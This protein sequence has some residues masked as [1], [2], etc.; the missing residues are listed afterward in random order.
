M[1]RPPVACPGGTA[2]EAT[3]Q[4]AE[5]LLTAGGHVLGL[6]LVSSPPP[7][8]QDFGSSPPRLE[9][10]SNFGSSPPHVQD[11]GSSPPHLE[12]SLNFGS[13]PPHVQDLDPLGYTSHICLFGMNAM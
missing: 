9:A 7:H 11:F 6:F 1:D 3:L 4:G 2:R 10:S 5:P 12:A 13:S 8:V